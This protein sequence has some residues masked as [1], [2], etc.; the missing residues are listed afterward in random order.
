MAQGTSEDNLEQML[1]KVFNRMDAL[2]ASRQEVERLTE[3]MHRE[4]RGQKGKLG[5]LRFAA[6]EN[7][8]SDLSFSVALVDD[9]QNGMVMTSIYGRHES[10]VYAKPIENGTS[11]YAL[12]EEEKQALALAVKNNANLE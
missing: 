10:R 4:V 2:E 5:I 8:G 11:S 3:A 7:E 1:E 12:S 6:F 9:N